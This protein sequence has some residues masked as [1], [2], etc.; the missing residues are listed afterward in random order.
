MRTMSQEHVEIVTRVFEAWNE[1]R[2]EPEEVRAVGKDRVVAVLRE[3][4][5]GRASGIDVASRGALFVRVPVSWTTYVH[6]CPS[7]GV[8][9]VDPTPAMDTTSVQG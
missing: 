7:V 2:L 9:S 6:G 3:V 1:Y 8:R 5:R 4:A